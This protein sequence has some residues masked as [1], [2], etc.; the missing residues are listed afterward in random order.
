MQPGAVHFRCDALPVITM[1]VAPPG[2]VVDDWV[3][4]R[5]KSYAAHEMGGNP[6]DFLRERRLQRGERLTRSQ[7]VVSV[8][9]AGGTDGQEGNGHHYPGD[10]D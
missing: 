4:V 5:R 2:A 7:T 6:E 9:W 8:R 10:S 3:A 1:K